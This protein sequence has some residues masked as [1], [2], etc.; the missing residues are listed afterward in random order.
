[1]V[2]SEEGMSERHAHAPVL[3]MVGKAQTVGRTRP[4]EAWASHWKCGVVGVAPPQRNIVKGQEGMRI[5]IACL[6]VLFRRALQN[7]NS[8]VWH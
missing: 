3:P 6:L 4:G 7:V 2:G 5:R 8:S 1:M